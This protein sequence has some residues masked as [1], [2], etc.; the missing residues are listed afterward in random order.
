[1]HHL[2]TV[3][4]L[5]TWAGGGRRGELLHL[6]EVFLFFNRVPVGQRSEEADGNRGRI[7]GKIKKEDTLTIVSAS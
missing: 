4:P 5:G 2:L 6:T 7:N 3:V 1:M